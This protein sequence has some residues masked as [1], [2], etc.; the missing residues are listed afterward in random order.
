MAAEVVGTAFVAIRALTTQLAGDIS[1]GVKKGV[2]DSNVDKESDKLGNTIGK[3][4]AKSTGDGFEDDGGKE[5]GDALDNLGDDSS[6]ERGSSSLGERIGAAVS[7]N[8]S[9]RFEEDSGRSIGNRLH[10]MGDGDPDVRR[11]IARLGERIGRGV[12]DFLSEGFS[13]GMKNFAKTLDSTLGK[14]KLPFVV[15]AA[16]LGLPALGGALQAVSA[17]AI[18]AVGILGQLATAAAGAGVALAGFGAGLVLAVVPILLAFKT[19]TPA[20]KAFREE[21]KKLA[22]PF[23]EIGAAAQKGVLP[24]VLNLVSS[25]QGLIPLLSGFAEVIGEIFGSFADAAGEILTTDENIQFLSTTLDNAAIIFWGVTDAVL[26]L[27]D[28]FL[29][30]LSVLTPLGVQLA[31]S[32]KEMAT[33]LAEFIKAGVDDG[34]LAS[35]F[36]TWYDRAAGIVSI[37]GDMLTFLWNVLSVGADS[38]DTMFG[39]FVD[40]WDRWAEFSSSVEGQNKIREIFDNALPIAHEIWLLLKDIVEI[41]VE[42][43]LTGD[44]DSIVGFLQ[45]LRLEWLPAI[46][47]L[48]GVVSG[49]AAGPLSEL[50]DALGRFI[51][52]LADN[53]EV[54]TGLFNVFSTNLMLLAEGLNL[55]SAALDTDLGAKLAPVILQILLFAKVLSSLGLLVPTLSIA[56]SLA[57]GLVSALITAVGAIVAAV[58]APVLIVAAII[59]AVIAAFALAYFHIQAFRDFIDGIIDFFQNLTI[60]DVLGFF[61]AIPEFFASLPGK[62]GDA[63]SQLPGVITT[64]FGN[65]VDLAGRAL[66]ALPGAVLGILNSVARIFVSVMSTLPSRLGGII[67]TVITTLVGWFGELAPK[68]AAGMGQFIGTVLGFLIS[69]PIK[70]LA[71]TPQII[72]AFLD[73]LLK[74]P[75]R[76]IELSGSVLSAIVTVFLQLPGLVGTILSGVGELVVTFFTGLPGMVVSIIDGFIQVVVALF[77]ALPDLVWTA[78]QSFGTFIINVIETAAPQV[79]EAFGG[80]V[81][82]WL[83]AVGEVP[84]MVFDALADLGSKLKEA[85]TTAWALF[86]EGWD[87]LR[88]QAITVIKEMPGKFAEGLSELGGKLKTVAMEAWT[89]L[90][91]GL[92]WLWDQA[93]ALITGL[94]GALIDALGDLGGAL[95][96]AIYGAFKVAWNAMVSALPKFSVKAF[97]V[98]IEISADFLKLAQGG[99]I[100]RATAAIIGEAGKE[101][102]IPLTRPARAV[103]LAQESGLDR[104]LASSSST[105]FGVAAGAGG[106]IAMVKVETLNVYD[107]MDADILAAKVRRAYLTA[108]AS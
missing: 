48:A 2:S 56:S 103:Q 88:E 74:L 65:L 6:V 105:A 84:G 91:E 22:Q 40:F 86:Q 64:G 76:I 33:N 67:A 46:E 27:L 101:V 87:W 51:Q 8:V 107:Q 63:L 12:T 32:L 85:I 57:S 66:A 23:N 70:I 10:T 53:P 4:I 37:L 24:G 69:L 1:D 50:A 36:Q 96:D 78:L 26:A 45:T 14:I 38:T 59:A 17:L 73:F 41:L 58:S 97:G 16:L 15:D 106:E 30:L 52:V 60:D 19:E 108:M 44:T 61:E 43:V 72:L 75:A 13:D 31:G 81:D 7:K 55:L 9:K 95:K 34:S 21:L 71:L 99:I 25:L 89:K 90:K 68:V 3:R 94:P 77:A 35:T 98:G 93:V 82:E 104:I 29:P 80:L 92:D 28:A 54:A 18:T 102:V 62:V 79:L 49:A 39:G 100:D 83:A 5:I 47:T 11:G 42:P 20:L